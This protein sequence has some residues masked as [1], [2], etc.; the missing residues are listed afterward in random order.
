[1]RSI[2]HGEPFV[3]YDRNATKIYSTPY[4]TLEGLNSVA[5]DLITEAPQLDGYCKYWHDI[6]SNDR[7]VDRMEKRMAEFL[8]KSR[9]PLTA[10]T[11]IG[12]ISSAKQQEVNKIVAKYNLTIP[13]VVKPNWYF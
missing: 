4:T 2:G 1:M 11:R 13:T 6:P 12:V 8:V 9:V 3:I 5:W 7:Y 10:V